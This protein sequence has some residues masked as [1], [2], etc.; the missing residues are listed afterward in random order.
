MRVRCDA[1][2]AFNG[3]VALLLCGQGGSCGQYIP[4]LV[5]ETGLL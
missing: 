2:A 5:Y 3:T 4:C 1:N